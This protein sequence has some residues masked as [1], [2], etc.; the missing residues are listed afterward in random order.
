MRMNGIR[1][2]KD[3]V[4]HRPCKTSDVKVM[5]LFFLVS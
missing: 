1:F 4:E 2:S 3:V 5:L